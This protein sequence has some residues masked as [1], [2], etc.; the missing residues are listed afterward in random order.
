MGEAKAVSASRDALFVIPRGRGDGFRASIRGHLLEL[1]D[2][3]SAHG[4]APTPDDLLIVSIASDFAW[5]ARG[6]L[7]ACGI[8]D[9]VSVSAG[10][11]TRENAPRLENLE[12]TV[13]VAKAAEEMSEALVAAPEDRVAARSLHALLPI[14]VRAE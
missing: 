2:P 11:R 4:L 10:W 8:E 9:Y 12:V 5:F 1:A 7:R 3:N 13:T 14:R 6:F